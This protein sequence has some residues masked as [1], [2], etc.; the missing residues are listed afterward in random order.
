MRPQPRLRTAL[1]AG[2]LA[3]TLTA[4]ASESE[5]AHPPH[6]TDL[7]SAPDFHGGKP[8]TP[9]T[10]AIWDDAAKRA[11]VDAATATMNA[12]VS[13]RG[14]TRDAWW[15][16]LS[17]HLDAIAT[18]DYAWVEPSAIPATALTGTVVVTAG[19]A[20]TLAYATVPTNAGEYTLTL[21][22][23]DGSSPWEAGRIEPANGS[24]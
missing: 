4:C 18:R 6:E 1:L 23:K 3:M 19:E 12:Y 10:E 7:E 20:P 11:A 9:E 15:A 24:R 13:N 22:R 2:I 16:A 5:P 17:P 21:S 8:R 14:K